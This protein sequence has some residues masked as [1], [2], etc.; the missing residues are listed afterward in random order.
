MPPE[1]AVSE[2]PIV[3]RRV[4]RAIAFEDALWPLLVV[5]FTGTATDDEFERYLHQMTVMLARRQPHAV[6]MDATAAHFTPTSHH[7][8]Q[9]NWIRA[10]KTELAELSAGTAFVFSSRLFRVVISGVFMLQ[11]PPSPYA[12]FGTLDEAVRWSA[13]QLGIEPPANRLVWD[14]NETTRPNA[15]Q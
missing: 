3:R 7:R 15:K 1:A 10:H 13:A 4:S 12:I 11:P 9:A 2:Q 6:I 5:R 14:A 8:M